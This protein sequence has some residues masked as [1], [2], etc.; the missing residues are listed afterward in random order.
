[1]LKHHS[2]AL[3]LFLLCGFQG[4]EEKT[5]NSQQSS[6]NT[7]EPNVHKSSVHQTEPKRLV[8]EQNDE[9]FTEEKNQERISKVLEI[10]RKRDAGAV[11]M[12]VENLMKITP[13]ETVNLF[14]FEKTYPCSAA[15]IEIGDPAILKVQ[16]QFIIAKSGPEQMVLLN[17]LLR[18]KGVKFAADWLEE[19]QRMKMLPERRQRFVGLRNWVLS[20]SE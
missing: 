16:E 4:C 7:H 10:G 18:I 9:P 3:V 5:G 15:L 17:V 11:P 2:L 8:D 1:M 6:L 19:I 13:L 12:L 20:H 14:D